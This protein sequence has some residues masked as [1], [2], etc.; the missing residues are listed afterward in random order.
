[1]LTGFSAKVSLWELVASST[2]ILRKLTLNPSKWWWPVNGDRSS[3]ETRVQ[4]ASRTSAAADIEP[5][6]I[7]SLASLLPGPKSVRS[8]KRDLALQLSFKQT[9]WRFSLSKWWCWK[10]SKN[11]FVKNKI[12]MNMVSR[13]CCTYKLCKSFCVSFYAPFGVA[14]QFP[15]NYY[16]QKFYVYVELIQLISRLT[17]FLRCSK[18]SRMISWWP[19][20]STCS[21]YRSSTVMLSRPR[22]VTLLLMK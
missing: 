15:K 11:Y 3:H 20:F 2:P 22:P 6:L 19:S 21:L 7:F 10:W 18:P 4:R 17:R 1:M 16:Y 8:L 9:Y 12:W 5:V 14:M 13:V